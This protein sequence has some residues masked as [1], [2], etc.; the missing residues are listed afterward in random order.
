MA[1]VSGASLKAPGCAH[2]LR[3]HCACCRKPRRFVRSIS[4]EMSPQI[5]S[6]A[7]LIARFYH[8]RNH[9]HAA[10]GGVRSST[11]AGHHSRAPT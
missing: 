7:I 8:F 5:Q 1:Y 10:T 4:P 11:F 9:D 2:D 3:A 6:F